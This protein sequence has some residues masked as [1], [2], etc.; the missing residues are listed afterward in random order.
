MF[1]SSAP[2]SFNPQNTADSL[3]VWLCGDGEQ[4]LGALG[5]GT[6]MAL[7]LYSQS[8]LCQALVLPSPRL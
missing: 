5:A 4:E 2:C 8:P 7:A 6:R 1:T 3:S